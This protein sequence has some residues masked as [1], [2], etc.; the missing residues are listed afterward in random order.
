MINFIIS[1]FAKNEKY[2]K[3]ARRDYE[4]IVLAQTKS[5]R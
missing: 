2:G 1:L 3:I 5:M 4:N